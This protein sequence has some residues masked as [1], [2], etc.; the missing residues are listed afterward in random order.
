MGDA[1]GGSENS[2]GG[3]EGPAPGPTE[4]GNSGSGSEGGNSEGGNTP[5]GNNEGGNNEGGN[6]PGGN[7]E[8]KKSEKLNL[9]AAISLGVTKVV[10]KAYIKS[11]QIYANGL[12]IKATNGS[13]GTPLTSVDRAS[14]GTETAATAIGG[15]VA[16]QVVTDKTSAFIAKG[17]TV[18]LQTDSPLSVKA[19]GFDK[20]ITVADG[21]SA[22]KGE[23][24][25]IGAG[26]AV[27]VNGQDV[28]SG[29]EDG[30]EKKT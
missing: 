14:A 30:T 20:V 17:A 21:A 15:S 23:K 19:E 8:E 7:T 10:N 24:V 11:G 22:G 26:L 27:A 1:N 12:E 16:V 4:G 13:A 25:G 6:T 5:G 18:S 28:Y 29:V 2:E 3:N 9:G